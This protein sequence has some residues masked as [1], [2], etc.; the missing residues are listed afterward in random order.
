MQANC[1]VARGIEAA[2]GDKPVEWRLPTNLP[3]SSLEQAARM[4]DCYRS[5]WGI[6]IFFQ[7]LKRAATWTRCR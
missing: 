2:A 7:V 1:I 6:Q 3:A 4:I 5:R